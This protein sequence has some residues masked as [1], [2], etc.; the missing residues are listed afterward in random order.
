MADREFILLGTG[1]SVGVPTIGCACDVCRSDNPRLHRTRA[2]ALVQTPAGR[3]LIDTGP[4]LRQ[5]FLREGL[6]HADAILMTHHHADHIFGLDDVR[7]FAHY[8]DGKPLPL[9]CDPDV[10]AVLRRAYFYVFDD[11]TYKHSKA[12]LPLVEIRRIERPTCEILGTSFIPI[13]LKHGPTDVLGF[14]IGDLAYCT[15]VNHIPETSWPLLEGLDVLILDALRMTPHPTHF[16]LFEALA[17]IQRLAPKHAYLTHISCRLD[18]V[19]AA[20][21]LPA[22]VELSYD[23]LRIPIH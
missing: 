17:V 1:T 3:I 2:S 19:E 20:K 10:E 22:N 18:P 7:V 14:R 16:S 6:S 13:P 8:R 5:Q 12:A 21:H 4:D 15:D 9:Y 11:S 23:G